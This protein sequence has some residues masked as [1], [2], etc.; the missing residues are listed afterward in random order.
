MRKKYNH[1]SSDIKI[2]FV[3]FVLMHPWCAFY[4]ETFSFQLL[5]SPQNQIFF[6]TCRPACSGLLFI[7]SFF[8]FLLLKLQ[9]VKELVI[10]FEKIFFLIKKIIMFYG[11]RCFIQY[12]NRWQHYKRVSMF[13]KQCADFYTLLPNVETKN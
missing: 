4:I 12:E 7:I 6:F 8:H 2:V 5:Q 11:F 9:I 10:M 13:G 1:I 3:F